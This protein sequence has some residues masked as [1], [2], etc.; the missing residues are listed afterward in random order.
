MASPRLSCLVVLSQFCSPLNSK[1]L[2]TARNA[3]KFTIKNSSLLFYSTWAKMSA[4]I[5]QPLK[6][7]TLTF[8]HF[9]CLLTTEQEFD[10]LVYV[11]I[12]T[13]SIAEN[14]NP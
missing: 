8:S 14:V 10:S 13:V 4:L 6:L 1:G 9:V 11:I 5:T 2:N 3:K 12:N 7:P